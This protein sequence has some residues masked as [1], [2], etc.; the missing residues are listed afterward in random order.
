MSSAFLV[1]SLVTAAQLVAAPS[2]IG[3]GGADDGT[4]P[5]PR[6]VFSLSAGSFTVANNVVPRVEMGE[7]R[8]LSVS[9]PEVVAHDDVPFSDIAKDLESRTGD[10]WPQ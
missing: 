9:P 5:V 2:P 7:S 4:T 6:S 3:T 1:V 10:D 8:L